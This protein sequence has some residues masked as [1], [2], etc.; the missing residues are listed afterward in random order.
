MNLVP[1][2]WIPGF[3]LA[4]RSMAFCTLFGLTKEFTDLIIRLIGFNELTEDS[5]SIL[6]GVKCHQALVSSDLLGHRT[7]AFH[8]R[9]FNMR[10]FESSAR[11]YFSS[12]FES[13]ISRSHPADRALVCGTVVTATMWS[14]LNRLCPPY[15]ID[16]V[17][18][19]STQSLL[20]GLPPYPVMMVS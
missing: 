8:P 7:P 10:D 2:T 3:L 5:G 6:E 16:Y 18:G 14:N 19:S 4:R 13:S 17:P 12:G 15:T 9:A 11:R 1:T 20:P